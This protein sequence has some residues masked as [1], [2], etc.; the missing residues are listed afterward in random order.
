LNFRPSGSRQHRAHPQRAHIL[1]QGHR[2]AVPENHGI[3][4]IALAI[5]RAM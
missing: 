4:P 1:L 2:R 3:A 5:R